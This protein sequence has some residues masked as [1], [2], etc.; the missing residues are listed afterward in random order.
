MPN[1]TQ[2]P[3]NL[4]VVTQAQ[5]EQYGNYLSKYEVAAYRGI[6][7]E[8]VDP[9]FAS[10]ELAG[11]YTVAGTNYIFSR[12]KLDEWVENRLK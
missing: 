3:S 5:D 9:L 2:V 4:S 10:G 7:D 11:T 1:T 8:D 6:T 12:E